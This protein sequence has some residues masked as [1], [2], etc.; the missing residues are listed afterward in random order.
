[1]ALSD[2]YQTF[3]I[4]LII[5][6]SI[7][8]FIIYYYTKIQEK[9]TELLSFSTKSGRLW[10][11]FQFITT[12]IV[13]IAFVIETYLVQI[14]KSL[15]NAEFIVLFIFF[16]DYIFYFIISKNKL[17][18]FLSMFAILDFIIIIPFI[19]LYA[20]GNPESSDASKPLRALRV[21]RI[22]RTFRFLSLSKSILRR[23]IEKLALII[24]SLLFCGAGIMQFIEDSQHLSFHETIYFIVISISTVGYGDISPL[25]EIGK[26]A[27]MFTILFTLVLVPVQISKVID[28]SI[29][30]KSEETKYTKNR[31]HAIIKSSNEF[32]SLFHLLIEF[33]IQI[34]KVREKF[35]DIV[36]I[37]DQEPPQN[38]KRIFKNPFFDQR[39][40]V[41]ILKS[42]NE[43]T[44][45]KVSIDTAKMC[46]LLAD[47]Q[48]KSR[49]KQDSR[50]LH[51]ALTIQNFKPKIKT[52]LQM[53]DFGGSDSLTNFKG[54]AILIN[55]M[56]NSI[57]ALNSLY[58]GFATF[59]SNLIQST[60]NIPYSDDYKF[61]PWIQEY[62]IGMKMEIFTIIFPQRFNQLTFIEACTKIYSSFSAILIGVIYS[63]MDRKCTLL[64]NPGD[65]YYIKKGDVGY[66]ICDPEK[67]DEIAVHFVDDY[68][69]EKDN[70]NETKTSTDFIDTIELNEFNPQ[71]HNDLDYEFHFGVEND[72]K[73]NKQR[74][75]FIAKKFRSLQKTKHLKS[76]SFWTSFSKMYSPII[77]SITRMSN[78]FYKEDEANNFETE[79]LSTSNLAETNEENKLSSKHGK[80]KVDDKKINPNN[81]TLKK[82][83]NIKNTKNVEYQKFDWINLSYP[84]PILHQVTYQEVILFR[85][86]N[87]SNHI[88][89]LGDFNNFFEF[90]CALRT[91]E[92]SLYFRKLT[93]N[94]SGNERLL[95]N[96][97]PVLYS[98]VEWLKKA[99]WK[100]IQ[101]EPVIFANVFFDDLNPF[102]NFEYSSDRM[103]QNARSLVVTDYH[104]LFEPK[105]VERKLLDSSSILISKV[106]QNLQN[107]PHFT[108]NLNI[109]SNALF[110]GLSSA[111]IPIAKDQILD[112]I[113]S[114]KNYTHNVYYA[115]SNVFTSVIFESLMVQNFYK[116][117]IIEI[118][119][120]FIWDLPKNLPLDLNYSTFSVIDIP[121]EFE[122][123]TFLELFINLAQFKSIVV[124]GLYRKI[125]GEKHFYV[126]TNPKQST[127]CLSSDRLLILLLHK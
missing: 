79:N 38:I 94:K 73:I 75:E 77:H 27:M 84:Y 17:K 11:L 21:F 28:L 113:L 16:I 82:I 106:V 49:I 47:K 108:I 118:M 34:R 46:I 65:S 39:I 20:R 91:H 25:T 43:F 105:D 30:Y 59:I 5:F 22:F 19:I 72:K 56:K 41:V 80:E 35:F 71:G 52:C 99:Q 24:I 12:V 78:S 119:K 102:L 62:H 13:C 97:V 31:K 57:I 122:N 95:F 61:I 55:G 44:L 2:I 58:P 64:L 126:V 81:L 33:G 67:I 63:N 18:Y 42:L 101:D 124:L 96:P 110:L 45:E 83:T 40:K 116:A 112:E 37:F 123:R 60:P 53:I 48:E 76:S 85:I 29:R 104:D 8:S 66:I 93:Q 107:S 121:Q 3:I 117:D 4:L 26:M 111:T 50:I 125:I 6:F 9:L 7:P 23:S 86:K 98:T 92:L 103:I 100:L 32:S 114:L 54:D 69:L 89:F 90:V 70:L 1:M 74:K 109:P 51:D 15:L 120:A 115:S 10:D 68:F 36:I 14:P 88:L 127:I 87:M